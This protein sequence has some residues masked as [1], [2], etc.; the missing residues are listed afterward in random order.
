[1]AGEAVLECS[2]AS[3][4]VRADLDAATARPDGHGS[5]SAT[6]SPEAYRR[7]CLL[8]E[9]DLISYADYGAHPHAGGFT[10]L[11]AASGRC[12]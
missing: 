2:R 6:G 7:H 3:L 5:G 4:R 9:P 11:W 8:K 1:M 10:H 12:I